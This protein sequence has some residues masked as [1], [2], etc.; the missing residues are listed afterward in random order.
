MKKIFSIF[1]FLFFVSCGGDGSSLIDGISASDHRVFVTST[2]YFADEVKSLND[3]DSICQS[4][5]GDAGLKLT[6]K[7]ILSD[8]STYVS[9]RLEFTGSIYKVDSIDEAILVAS[10]GSDLWNT[11]STNLL[12][13]INLTESGSEVSHTPWTGTNSN[14]GTYTGST[15]TSW[16]STSGSGFVGN[17]TDTGAAWLE[18][19]NVPCSE[20]HPIYCISQ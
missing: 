3:A 4:I 8:E 1:I 19:N 5:A 14:G 2:L 7:A 16:S 6:Y 15:C 10:T 13:T 9:S 20:K 12:S 18:N 11:D 17:T